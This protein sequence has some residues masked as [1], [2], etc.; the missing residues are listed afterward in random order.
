MVKL[1][2]ENNADAKVKAKDGLGPLDLALKLG[3]A[4]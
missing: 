3:K 2:I 1:L 4:V